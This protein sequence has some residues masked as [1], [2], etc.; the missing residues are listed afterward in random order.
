MPGAEPTADMQ[1]GIAGIDKIMLDGASPVLCKRARHDLT[2]G[3]AAERSQ[4]VRRYM[5]A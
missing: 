4:C 2:R 1:Q 3:P 5:A